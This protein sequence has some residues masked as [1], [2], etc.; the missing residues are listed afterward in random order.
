MLSYSNVYETLLDR[1]L[2]ARCFWDASKG[3][4][5]QRRVKK[6]LNNLPYHVDVVYNMLLDESFQSVQHEPKIINENSSKKTRRIIRPDF[7]YEQVFHHLV[8]KPFSKI[9]EKSIYTLS[10]ANMKGRGTHYGD[11]HVRRILGKYSGKK[12]YILKMD[13]HHY[14]DSID[15]TIL[16]AK[17]RKMFKDDKYYNLLCKLIDYDGNE[18]GIGIPLGYYTSQWFGNFYLLEFDYY[19][20]QVLHADDYIRYADDMIVFGPNKKKLHKIRRQIDDYLKDALHLELKSNWQVFRFEYYDSKKQKVRGRALDFL[21]FVYHYN[22]KT[23]RKS[24]ISRARKK[25]YRIKKSKKLTWYTSTQML[26][27]MGWFKHTDTYDYFKK[28][29]YCNVKPKQM[30]RVVSKHEKR[31]SQ[32]ENIKWSDIWTGTVSS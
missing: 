6:I 3:K 19:V 5:N 12:L 7:A 4:R 1:D 21:G 8:M 17:L 28:Y 29:I 15:R 30:R 16:K 23:L 10:C 18:N 22:R 2:I 25:A 32:Y 24:I 14:Y 26:S 31:G 9:I 13:I 27:Y 11:R 20:K